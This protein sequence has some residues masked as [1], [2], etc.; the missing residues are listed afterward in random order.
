MRLSSPGLWLSRAILPVC[1]VMLFWGVFATSPNYIGIRAQSPSAGAP[2]DP[3]TAFA[4][5]LAEA[6]KTG[7]EKLFGAQWESTAKRTAKSAEKSTNPLE[8]KVLWNQARS[9]IWFPDPRWPAHVGHVFGDPRLR[10]TEN[11]TAL[12]VDPLGKFLAAGLKDGT[13]LVWEMPSARP[14]HRLVGLSSE[15]QALAFH[16]SGARLSGG[17]KDD[18]ILTW[19]MDD[20][21][22]VDRQTGHAEPINSIAYSP[23]G[24]FFAAAGADRKIRVHSPLTR[25]PPR[26]ISGPALT[27]HQISYSPDGKRIAAASADCKAWVFEVGSGKVL[28][29]QNLF[30][31]GNAYG[32]C[33]V[34]EGKTLAV[35]GANPNQLKLIDSQTGSEVKNLEPFPKP[36]QFLQSA[37]GGK[38]VMAGSQDG[39]LRLV[40]PIT[41]QTL[42]T[43]QYPDPYRAVALAADASWFVVAGTDMVLRTRE[44]EHQ[45]TGQKADAGV[46]EIWSLAFARDGLQ[47]LV[48]GAK[49]GAILFDSNGL[50]RTAVLPGSEGPVSVVASSPDSRLLAVGGVDRKIRV[51]SSESAPPM[52]LEGHE[53]TITAL[54]F[55]PAG[56]LLASASADRTVKV[57][58]LLTGKILQSIDQPVGFALSLAIDS[59]GG[60]LAIGGGDGVI[61]LL[62][63]FGKASPR[64]LGGH[65]GAVTSLVFD[66]AR[67]RLASCGNDQRAILW[68]LGTGPT[69][70]PTLS[71]I[72]LN[73]S[74]G[75]L[76]AIAFA[77]SGLSVAAAGADRIIRLWDTPADSVTGARLERLAFRGHTDWVT[78][79]AFHPTANMILSGSVDGQLRTWDLVARQEDSVQTGHSREVRSLAYDASGQWLASS[80]GDGDLIAW[81]VGESAKTT[82]PARLLGSGEPLNALTWLGAERKVAVVA[83]NRTLTILEVPTG[84]VLNSII[85]GRPPI[86]IPVLGY[87]LSGKSIMAWIPPASMEKVPVQSGRRDQL[88]QLQDPAL[89]IVRSLALSPDGEVMV[90][91]A[92][93][94]TVRFWQTQTGKRMPEGELKAQTEG[95]ADLALSRGNKILAT[96]DKTGRVTVWNYPGREKLHTLPSPG[97]DLAAL[98]L[99]ADGSRVLVASGDNQITLFDIAAGTNLRT[100]DLRPSMGQ[101]RSRIRAMAFAPDR[102]VAALGLSDGLILELELP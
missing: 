87:S 102:P 66:P 58:D 9:Q 100:W 14:L 53:G 91:G 74:K 64:L 17:G 56:K 83:Q 77:P 65:Q 27:I 82:A 71:Q 59:T 12:A 92:D 67:P 61:R 72:S 13:V 24:V 81:P 37:P 48:G 63:L 31:G 42:R 11:A 79:L 96:S 10:V 89:G 22:V 40:D 49:G 5:D 44:L 55:G 18:L 3:K 50:S 6:K 39:T 4:E 86:E 54:A 85:D 68:T 35:S 97:K 76:S 94:G 88:M 29:E 90:A 52:V 98:A 32:I 36:V 75:A 30:P 46:G 20:G 60:I 47:V 23:D 33:F 73:G 19:A 25:T 8:S 70:Q 7:A 78:T 26:E 51:F 16:P 62:D 28:L 93:D 95:V 34:A 1:G 84:K 69:G 2:P 38:L 45:S 101:E 41:G 21:K 43:H 80:G 15:V 99:K 57:W